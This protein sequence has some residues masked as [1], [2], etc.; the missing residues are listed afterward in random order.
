MNIHSNAMQCNAIRIDARQLF[1]SAPLLLNSVTSGFLFS[2]HWWEKNYK[3]HRP[4]EVNEWK[5]CTR[6][7]FIQTLLHRVQ[8]FITMRLHISSIFITQPVLFCCI[9]FK[10]KDNEKNAL[11]ILF[12]RHNFMLFFLNSFTFVFFSRF[13]LHFFYFFFCC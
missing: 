5:R 12:Q 13:T 2:C 10:M 7:K 3:C 9:H 8:D 11:I 4:I 6:S 1:F